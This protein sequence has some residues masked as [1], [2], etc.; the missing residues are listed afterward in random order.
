MGHLERRKSFEE[1]NCFSLIYREKSA[2]E[3]IHIYIWGVQKRSPF[4]ID[5]I[6]IVDNRPLII[7]KK[8]S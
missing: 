7:R 3:F 6:T 2:R 1:M 5:A 8:C 4:S